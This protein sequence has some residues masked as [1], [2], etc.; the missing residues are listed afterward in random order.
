M[1]LVVNS[2]QFLVPFW[3][4]ILLAVAIPF[5]ITYISIPTILTVSHRLGLYE[6]FKRENVTYR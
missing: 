4:V 6:R 3:L 2:M 5:L 1:E